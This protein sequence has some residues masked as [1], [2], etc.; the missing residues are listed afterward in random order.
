MRIGMF[1]DSYYPTRDGVV[2][3]LTTSRKILE[4]LGHKVIV[5]APDDPGGKAPK[6]DGTYYLPAT[7]FSQ[8]E[9]YRL[10]IYPSKGLYDILNEHDVEVLHTHGVAFMGLKSMFASRFLKKPVLLTY[11]TMVTEAQYYLPWNI[12]ADFMR[13]LMWIYLRQF[14]RRSDGV[15]APT[16]AIL[17]ELKKEAPLKFTAVIPTG[18]D[19][20]RFNPRVDG[21]K[22]REILGVGEKKILLHVG[23]VAKE[24][25][26]EMVL[27][28]FKG[29]LRR[30]PETLLLVAGDGPAR[31]YYE[32]LAKS[33]GLQGSVKF[34]GFVP[35][36]DLPSYY[37]AADAF[38][39]AS[40]FETQGI[41]VMEALA[42]G[43]PVA[44]INY[45]AIAEIIKD[46]H[47]GY[48][49]DE[50]PGK[51]AEAICKALAA[52]D[53]MRK[54][55]WETAQNY[56]QRAC[57]ERLVDAYKALLANN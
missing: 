24:K 31:T 7:K 41:V 45:R 5:F 29:V 50:E 57:T 25:N 39:I 46:G 44:G 27:E 33:K 32:G 9:G 40:K 10:A 8:Y 2:T 48:L 12:D 1:T 56:E 26:I 3:S 16:N 13:T 54:C 55:A 20:D 34:A 22:V 49:F 52:S 6:E 53:D 30:E 47:S 11:H 18:I 17:E 23:R 42:S 36:A 28:S 38:V 43:V 51:C 21:S 19:L 35:D 37:A 15:V 4:E 14:L